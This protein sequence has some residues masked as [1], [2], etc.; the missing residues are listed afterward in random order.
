MTFDNEPLAALAFLGGLSAATGMILVSTL[1]L[2]IMVANEMLLPFMFRSSSNE[3]RQRQDLS[4]IMLMVRRLC[5][6]GIMAL[7]WL[8]YQSATNER[9]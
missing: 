3:L 7:A 6:I 1:A 8:Y 5:I 4:W 9:S 2:A